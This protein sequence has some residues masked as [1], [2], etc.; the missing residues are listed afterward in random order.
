[1]A[2]GKLLGLDEKGVIRITR[3][4]TCA[5]YNAKIFSMYF[6]A[7]KC[8]KHKPTYLAASEK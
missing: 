5:T 2:V 3:Y 1:M 7:L 6:H 4:C 8:E